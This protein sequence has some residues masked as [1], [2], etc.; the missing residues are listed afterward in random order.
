MNA[1]TRP[2]SLALPTLSPAW[3]KLWMEKTQDLVLLL[4]ETDC[5]VGFFQG[6]VFAT[7]DLYHWIGQNLADCVSADSSPKLASLLYNDAASDNL[8]ARWRH[9]NFLGLHS[10]V[11]PVLTK[12]MTLPADEFAKAI[13]CRDLRP[14]QDATNK[15]LALQHEFEQSNQSL[16]DRLQEKDRMQGLG[17]VVGTNEMLQ[18]IKQTTYTQAIRETVTILERQCLQALLNEAAG[19]HIRA[20]RMA[21]LSLDQWQEKLAFFE[22]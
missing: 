16:R 21:G 1:Y 20:A 9:I 17:K 10:Q 4:D 7:E 19:D 2:Q 12:C 6:G 8:E 3:V 14:L 18:M 22:N 5:V 11:I 15:F 13:F